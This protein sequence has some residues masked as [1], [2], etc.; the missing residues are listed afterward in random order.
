M[1]LNCGVGDTDVLL[2]Y[3]DPTSPLIVKSCT[4]NNIQW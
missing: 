2:E 4:T 1:T 3:E